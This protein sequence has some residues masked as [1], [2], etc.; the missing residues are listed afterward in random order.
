MRTA[1]WA[2]H[3]C[4]GRQTSQKPE[5]DKEVWR[6]TINEASPEIGWLV[7]P[8]A[9]SEV[10]AR[11]APFGGPSPQGRNITGAED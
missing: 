5:A 10:A 4:M 3:A 9:A 2:Q 6:T 7:G 11:L 8:L 1:E